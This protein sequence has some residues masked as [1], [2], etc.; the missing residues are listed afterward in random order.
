[1]YGGYLRLKMKRVIN[2]SSL[3]MH[4]ITHVTFFFNN[5]LMRVISDVGRFD[6]PLC[7]LVL[8]CIHHILPGSEAKEQQP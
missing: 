8:V 5:L 4:R 3:V 7:K 1:M 6:R 2:Y